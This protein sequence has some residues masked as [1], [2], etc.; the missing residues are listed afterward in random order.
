MF[1]PEHLAYMSHLLR[2]GVPVGGHT[3]ATHRHYQE[4]MAYQPPPST[5]W[6]TT[7]RRQT[8]RRSTR[9]RQSPRGSRSQQTSAMVPLALAIGLVLAQQISCQ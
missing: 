1:T 7:P 6:P 8:V 2:M 3:L 5:P 9:P 4:R